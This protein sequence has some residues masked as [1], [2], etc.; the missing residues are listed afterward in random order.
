[1]PLHERLFALAAECEPDPAAELN[2]CGEIAKALY[3]AA[4]RV[5]IIH[6]DGYLRDAGDGWASDL[7][8]ALSASERGEG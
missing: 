4:K 7:S 5:A 8:I 6:G 1:M 2:A 3:L